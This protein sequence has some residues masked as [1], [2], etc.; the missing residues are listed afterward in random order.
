M[1]VGHVNTDM[2][3]RLWKTALLQNFCF[4]SSLVLAVLG[5]MHYS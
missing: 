4:V 2:F 5:V 1:V 3:K